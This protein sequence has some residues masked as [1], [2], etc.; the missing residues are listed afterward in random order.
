MASIVIA[1]MTRLCMTV[2]VE[3]FPLQFNAYRHSS[4]MRCDVVGGAYNVAGALLRLGDEP[5]L[6]T[7]VGADPAGES[8]R[9]AIRRAGLAG[10]G[11]VT[12]RESAKT[13]IMTEPDGRVARTASASGTTDYP[14]E[15]FIERAVGADLAVIGANPFG[16]PFVRTAK[17]LLNLPVATD[18]H[19]AAD[20]DDT[21]VLPWLECADVLFRSHEQLTSTPQQWIG[22][23]L[24]RYPG[25]RIAAVGRGE[26]GCAMGLR[27]GRLV[28]IEAVSPRPVRST[29]GAGDALFASF[30]HGWLASGEPVEALESATV[31]AGWKV[32][33]ESAAEGFLTDRE[34]A[35]LRQ[36]YP[37]RT[38]V[39]SWR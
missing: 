20:A 7:L 21:Q 8:I 1:G 18:L 22:D 31:F 38:R 14:M 4:G 12:A 6:C 37:V 25:C 9:A 15:R 23:V 5:R 16:R 19:V 32:G 28:E 39:G 26:R 17:E 10:P 24:R 29:D 33:A 35:A 27:D 30:L 3:G 13:V 2:P 11:V 34:L 36:V